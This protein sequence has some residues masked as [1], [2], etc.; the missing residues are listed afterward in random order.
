MPTVLLINGTNRYGSLAV[1]DRMVRKS[2]LG[3]SGTAA[4]ADGSVYKHGGGAVRV[5]GG[6]I[7]VS[8]PAVPIGPTED[9]TIRGWFEFEGMAAQS[10]VLFHQRTSTGFFPFLVYLNTASGTLEAAAYN[11]GAALVGTGAVAFTPAFGTWYHVALTRNG[12]TLIVWLNGVAVITMNIGAGTSLYVA[13]P[14]CIGGTSDNDT[15]TQFNGRFDDFEVVRGECLYSSAFTPPGELVAP[16]EVAVV[17]Y[18]PSALFMPTRLA[19]PTPPATTSIK[20]LAVEPAQI[21]P[22]Y[23]YGGD[24]KV[25]GLVK[26]DDSPDY[27]VS[28]R[29]WL[30]RHRDGVVV[31]EQWSDPTTGA[32]LF[33]H[34]D[35]REKY[36]VVAFDHNNVFNAVI[37]ANITPEVM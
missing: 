22:H 4:S 1:V 19:G 3:F 36:F 26:I 2:L 13:S 24:G 35:R 30:H 28:R 11:S 37:A 25:P 34:V 7:T 6:S 17:S 27:P 14:L 9:F 20:R 18:S 33:S 8:D 12:G 15:R 29:V 16:D 5:N 21:R 31:G 10:P 23:H 32:Y